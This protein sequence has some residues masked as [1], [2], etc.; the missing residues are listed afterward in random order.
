ML[1]IPL[2][3]PGYPTQF[4]D[5]KIWNIC[6]VFLFKVANISNRR[7]FL[8]MNDIRWMLVEDYEAKLYTW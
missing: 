8:T 2:D 7:D 6:S 1:F 5:T 3:Y 4:S